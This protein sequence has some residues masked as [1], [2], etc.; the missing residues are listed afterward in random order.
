[1]VLVGEGRLERGDMR[2][3]STCSSSAV[4]VAITLCILFLIG[5]EEGGEGTEEPL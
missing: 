2:S 1:M 5:V 4:D 3:T